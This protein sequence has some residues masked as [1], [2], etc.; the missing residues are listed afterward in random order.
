M[1][2]Y[3]ILTVIILALLVGLTSCSKTTDG[4]GGGDDGDGTTGKLSLT[5]SLPMNA[6]FTR[7]IAPS[8]A[9]PITTWA[10][11][12]PNRVIILFVDPADGVI[13]DARKVEGIPTAGVADTPLPEKTIKTFTGVNSS[14]TG[15]YDVYIIGNY[16]TTW[17][18]G[19]MKGLPLSALTFSAPSAAGY[20]TSNHFDGGLSAGYDEVEDIFVAKQKGVEVK[21]DETRSHNTPFE[22]TRI[23]SLFRVRIDV[24][25]NAATTRN[26]KVS[27][28]APTTMV[29][30]RRAA[31]GYVLTGETEYGILPNPLINKAASPG[32]YSFANA[33]KALNVFYQSAPMK[34]TAPEAA[35]YTAPGTMLV[36]GITLW[37]E[38]KIFPGG[39][40]ATNQGSG[41]DKFDIVLSAVTADGSYIPSGHT[42]PVGMG[43]RVY[44]SG[45]VQNAVGPNQILELVVRLENAGTITLPPVGSYGSL[46]ITAS[47]VSWGDIIPSELPM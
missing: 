22:L 28:T 10:S 25:T 11:V 29:S 3:P 26:D 20:A 4:S 13:K 45:Q 23:N 39:S 47:I 17:S 2:K 43:T 27:F 42:E 6:P 19:V 21:A 32:T 30:I 1:K 9:K 18:L 34:N 8:T 37:N 44:W 46:N 33:T 41:L 14:P 31:T 12:N 24:T 5:L 38:Y 16:P 36:D 7:A 35:K 40:N 15:G